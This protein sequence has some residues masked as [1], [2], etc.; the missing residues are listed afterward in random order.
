MSKQ[1]KIAIAAFRQREEAGLETSLHV[2]IQ[3]IPYAVG[4]YLFITY[5]VGRLYASCG[6]IAGNKAIQNP[7]PPLVGI[8]AGK[9]G[10]T[11]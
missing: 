6:D 10:S 2:S 7:C 1:D 11:K 3:Y 9:T 8:L 4:T 5:L